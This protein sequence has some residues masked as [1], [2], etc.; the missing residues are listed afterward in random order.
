MKKAAVS[1]ILVVVVLL[2]LRVTAESQQPKIVA[3][4]C[5]LGASNS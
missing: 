2:A 3:R 1:S 4:I 5:F